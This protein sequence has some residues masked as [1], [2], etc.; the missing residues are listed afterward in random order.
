MYYLKDKDSTVH[1]RLP[2]ELANYLF[3]SARANNISVSEY[4]RCLLLFDMSNKERGTDNVNC[5]TD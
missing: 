4:V 3:D 5:E 2:R 1:F